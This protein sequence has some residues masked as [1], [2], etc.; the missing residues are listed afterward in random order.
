[1]FEKSHNPSSWQKN[2][3]ELLA[4]QSKLLELFVDSTAAVDQECDILLPIQQGA[5]PTNLSGTLFRNGPGRFMMG[6]DQY[7]HPF[8]GD[9]MVSK[10]SF[11]DKNI[12]YKNKYVRTK[13]LSA[14]TRANRML[15]RS[16]GT[17]IPGGLAKNLL[18]TQFKNAAN[19]NVI[20]HGGRL[21]ALWEGG[22]PHL[23]DPESLSTLERFNF[24]GQLKND[25][26]FFDALINPE[27]P[28]SAHPKVDP[29]SGIMYNF[30]T[31]FGLK[32]RLIFYAVNADGKLISRRYFD[33]K[34]LSFIHD[35]VITSQ[36]FALVFCSP[37]HFNILS[38]ISGLQAPAEGIYGNPRKS[39]SVIAFPL[40]GTEGK[41]P[42]KDLS[43]FQLPY[44]FVFHHINA[45]EVSD[46]MI[47]YSSEMPDFPSAKQVQR[48]LKGQ[49]LNYPTTQLV[50]YIF[51]KKSKK[52]HRQ[53]LPYQA[54][55]LPRVHE[56]QIGKEFSEFFANSS[57]NIEE[58][59]FLSCID[60]VDISG[61]VLARK[62]FSDSLIGEP[63]LAGDEKKWILALNFNGTS[64]LSELIILDSVNL[65]LQC[66]AQ[67]PHS[68]P[69]G[70][71]GNWYP[72]N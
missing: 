52:S 6:K 4:H 51:N 50:R 28:F 35:F 19:T 34:G 53:L 38:M 2:N 23:L 47:V 66:R 7:S 56:H 10:F 22:W 64:K 27:L 24:S 72:S 39:V 5:L 41:I 25:F 16:F 32:N 37:V 71:H 3:T 40:E 63:I 26:G 21:L 14:E 45:F 12:H 58:F 61:Q 55:E 13:E 43:Y 54:F 9:G 36:G 44:S 20:Q 1:M 18:R 60:R 17:N 70:L 8:D 29:A 65:Q 57:K 30:G 33:L 62:E 67:L 59:P 48:A 42:E 69:V 15:Y 46:E 31:V 68:Q 49:E 11:N